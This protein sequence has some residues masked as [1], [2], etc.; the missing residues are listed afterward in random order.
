MAELV[1]KVDGL[2]LSGDEEA[3]SNIEAEDCDDGD[4]EEQDITTTSGNS[5]KK[6]KKKKPKK[7]T[8]SASTTASAFSTAER[9]LFYRWGCSI[10]TSMWYSQ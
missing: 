6:K 3:D 1:N 5:K 7:K 8:G 10:L 9:E 2:K 4:D